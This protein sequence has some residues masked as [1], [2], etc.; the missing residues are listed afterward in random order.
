ML[1]EKVLKKR[2]K[3]LKK[4][5]QKV[6]QSSAN[7]FDNTSEIFE[8]RRIV[9]V[10]RHHGVPELRDHFHARCLLLSNLEPVLRT[11]VV[12]PVSYRTTAPHHSE[13][14]KD[15]SYDPLHSLVSTRLV[16]VASELNHLQSSA[17]LHSP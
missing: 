11:S 13:L 15:L 1:K 12:Q 8:I 3:V 16:S 9:F 7:Q 2:R 6:L 5:A 17:S 4:M 14:N 10:A